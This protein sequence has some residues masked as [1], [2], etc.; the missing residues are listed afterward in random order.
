MRK[1]IKESTVLLIQILVFYVTPLFAGPTDIM[2]M[3]LL[4]LMNTFIL[5]LII[6]SISNKK[7]KYLYPII[8]AIIFIPSVYIYYNDTALVHYIWYL[9]CSLI[10]MIIGVGIKGIIRI[11][12]NKK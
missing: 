11:I 3:V 4:M 9:V 8:T 12:K 6:G 2:G 5:S 7:I 10:G 1:Y